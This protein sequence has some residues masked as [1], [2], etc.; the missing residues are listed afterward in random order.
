MFIG[1]NYSGLSTRIMSRFYRSVL[2]NWSLWSALI[3]VVASKRWEASSTLLFE[4]FAERFRNWLWKTNWST[5]SSTPWLLDIETS[6]GLRWS[7]LLALKIAQSSLKILASFERKCERSDAWRAETHF[8]VTQG[9]E[10]TIKTLKQHFLLYLVSFFVFIVLYLSDDFEEMCLTIH[11]IFERALWVELISMRI[12]CNLV[13][14]VFGAF[15]F[16]A[17]L[18]VAFLASHH[19]LNL[20]RLRQDTRNCTTI[21]RHL[22]I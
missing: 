16:R 9:G 8:H 10:R 5:P 11:T 21:E 1:P 12:D 19:L 15:C 3:L 2:K 14:F 4:S 18:N 22:G 17:I 7:L 13:L 20:L 6:L